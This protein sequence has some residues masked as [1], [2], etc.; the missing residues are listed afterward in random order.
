MLTKI[1]K[2]SKFGSTNHF[3][4]GIYHIRPPLTPYQQELIAYKRLI[5]EYRLKN[6]KAYWD[7]QT[8]IENDF[9]GFFYEKKRNNNI[10]PIR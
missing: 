4:F 6:I 10:F 7:R 1:I 5:R 9:L 2:S 3:S 8:Q